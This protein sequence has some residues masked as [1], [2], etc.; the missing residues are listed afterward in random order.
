MTLAQDFEDFVKLLNK[1]QVDYMVVGGYA[2]A[3]HKAGKIPENRW[4]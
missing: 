4:N 1:H 3:F 2:L